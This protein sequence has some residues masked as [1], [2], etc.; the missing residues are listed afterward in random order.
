MQARSLSTAATCVGRGAAVV[1]AAV[2]ADAIFDRLFDCCLVVGLRI[3]CKR[4]DGA[5]ESGL[6]WRLLVRNS[7]SHMPPWW[8]GSVQPGVP[9]SRTLSPGSASAAA[10]PNIR[11]AR[12]HVCAFFLPGMQP[13]HPELAGTTPSSVAAMGWGAREETGGARAGASAGGRGSASAIARVGLPC[14]PKKE[15]SLVEQGV[16]QLPRAA[17]TA[18]FTVRL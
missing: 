13:K 5:M 14:S 8:S 15:N 17:L 16:A 9:H 1:V 12:A 3:G 6:R 11:A 7:D 2:L 18:R 10:P 4:R